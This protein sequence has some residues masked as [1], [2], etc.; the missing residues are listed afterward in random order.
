MCFFAF[1]CEPEALRCLVQE[2]Y[3]AQP[4]FESIFGPIAKF[5]V[6]ECLVTLAIL[7]PGQKKKLERL[8]IRAARRQKSR[9]GAAVQVGKAAIDP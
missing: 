1:V 3:R 9:R 8:A 4:R 7:G 5:L 2:P 6:L